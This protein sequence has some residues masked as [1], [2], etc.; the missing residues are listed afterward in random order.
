[1]DFA[2]IIAGITS[3]FD[4]LRGGL[5]ARD[6]AKVSA[7]TIEISQRLLELGQLTS[8]AQQEVATLRSSEG[9]LHRRIA[10]LEKRQTERDKY[11]LHEIRP[12]AFAYASQQPE[13]GMD[14]PQHY[15]CQPCFDDGLK[16]VL[17][18]EKAGDYYDARWHCMQDAAHSFDDPTR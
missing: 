14:T 3:A 2:S 17:R 6:D 4:L 9:E 15:L 10:E 1:M 12:G 18:F 11:S 7:A 5:R 16:R 8:T 13:A